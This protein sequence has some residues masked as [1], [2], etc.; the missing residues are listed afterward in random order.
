LL[1]SEIGSGLTTEIQKYLVNS[2]V[3]D[4]S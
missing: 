2:Y 4:S 3:F 1:L